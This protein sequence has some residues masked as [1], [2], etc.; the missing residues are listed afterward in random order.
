MKKAFTLIELL[1]TIA[2]LGVIGLITTLSV[3]KIIKINKQKLYDAEV[4]N[5]IEAAKLYYTDHTEYLPS[6]NT[7]TCVSLKRLQD[8]KLIDKNINNPVTGNSFVDTFAVTVKNDNNSYEYDVTDTCESTMMAY[9]SS[10]AYWQSAY[11][12]Y[13]KGCGIIKPPSSSSLFSF[14]SIF[15]GESFPKLRS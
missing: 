11:R 8:N 6:N 1:A 9:S 12:T 5:I 7:S 13:R 2:I 4:V 14:L 3:N 10:K 15:I